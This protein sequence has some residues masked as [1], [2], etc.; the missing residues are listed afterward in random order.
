MKPKSENDRIETAVCVC[1]CVYYDRVFVGKRS[2]APNNGHNNNKSKFATTRTTEPTTDSHDVANIA[3]P[4]VYGRRAGGYP[5]PTA[6]KV[7]TATGGERDLGRSRRARQRRRI[8]SAVL[9][10]RST[11]PS[12]RVVTE[13]KT[14]FFFLRSTPPPTQKHNSTSSQCTAVYDDRGCRALSRLFAGQLPRR[15]GRRR[16]RRRTVTAVCGTREYF[17]GQ[18]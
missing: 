10:S 9:L 16:R 7:T 6:V 18:Q 3:P 1:V 8:F 17:T 15:S 11:H 13:N 14:V 2:R 12:N 5:A 4:R